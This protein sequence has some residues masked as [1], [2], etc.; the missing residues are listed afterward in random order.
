MALI[1]FDYIRDEVVAEVRGNRVAKF[2][3]IPRTLSVGSLSNG[4]FIIVSVN[5]FS[6]LGWSSRTGLGV[7]PDEMVEDLLHT[8]RFNMFEGLK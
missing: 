3:Q 4:N 2:C 5:P 6:H 1:A 7:F 8:S